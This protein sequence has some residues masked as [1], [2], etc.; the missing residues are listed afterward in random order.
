MDL[1]QKAQEIEN[2][3]ETNP[4]EV[5]AQNPPEPIKEE[6][7]QL[8]DNTPQNDEVNNNSI[9]EAL[10]GEKH[11]DNSPIVDD[12]ITENPYDYEY[13]PTAE[14]LDALNQANRDEFYRRI[15]DDRKWGKD[16]NDKKELMRLDTP[17]VIENEPV[18]AQIETI[19]K[20]VDEDETIPPEQK[21][22]EKQRRI[23]SLSNNAVKLDT[24]SVPVSPSSSQETP[25]PK[26]I[27]EAG[28]GIGNILKSIS[29]SEINPSD[30]KTEGK[31]EINNNI[32]GSSASYSTTNTIAKEDGED[33]V[34]MR[35]A[36]SHYGNE[37]A[38]ATKAGLLGKKS[39][40]SLAMP[41]GIPTSTYKSTTLK[42][43]KVPQLDLN[44]LTL[45]D[46]II[47]KSKN[48]KDGKL[49]KDGYFIRVKGDKVLVNNTL[50]ENFTRDNP[51]DITKLRKI[52]MES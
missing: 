24:P 33:A 22:E 43:P 13:E 52:V 17:A 29:S 35:N 10:K 20:E 26:P 2:K 21:E 42:E 11:K 30:I 41:E 34:S 25:S 9:L 3:I 27:N 44:S 5:I 51:R 12:L 36:T 14:E 23:L 6:A 4:Q 7:E 16:R 8:L 15:A 18:I 45:K 32:P 48:W 46:L 37:G 49:D 1:Q 39:S 50:L 31:E 38:F 47:R 28:A 19:E 40:G